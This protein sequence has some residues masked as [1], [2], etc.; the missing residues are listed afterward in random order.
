MKR[1]LF[2]LAVSLFTSVGAF[3]QLQAGSVAPDFTLKDLNGTTY[4]LYT[5]LN[6]GKTVF[7]D[8]SAAWCA[9]C[10]AY[11]NS[12]AL[13]N[14][15]KQHGPAGAPNVNA[16]TTDDV[17]VLFVE[18]ESTNTKAQLT[19]TSTGTT[20]ANYTQG[21]WVTGTPYP[22]LDTNAAATTAF[23]TAYQ[24]GYF[25][26]IYM[27]CR[28]HLI[29]EVGQLT[30]SALYAAAQST[31]P[32]YAP[33]ATVD[34]KAVT[35]SSTGYFICSAN[36]TVK[37]QNYSTTNTI[38]AATIKV[39]SGSTVVSTYNWTGSAAPYEVK[40]VTLPSFT[41]TAFAPYKY[42]VVV[43]GD[44]RASNN[45]SAD[46]LF[47]VY[48][49]ST[50]GTTPWK[51]AFESSS[52][53][54]Y[55]MSISNGYMFPFQTNGSLTVIGVDGAMTRAICIDFPTMAVNGTSELVLGNFNTASATNVSLEFDAAYGQ[56]ISTNTDKL[57]VKVST[58]C[59]ATWST[60]WTKSGTALATTT[61]S[62]SVAFVPASSA[63]WSHQNAL[64]T[65]Y[66]GANM[67]VKIVATSNKG[68]YG[69]LDNIQINNSLNVA[70]VIAP[71]SVSVYPNPA[72]ESA[73]LDF[74]LSKSG[75][76]TVNV[77][78]AV[79]RTVATVANGNMNQGAQHVTIP[80]STLAPGV[81]NISIQTEEG[82][83]TQ[84]LAV[85]K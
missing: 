80:T 20:H 42:E 48:T 84:R 40:S 7:I 81:Y 18:G 62:S 16:T 37:F 66:K 21:N 70:N 31:C 64:L 27:V 53:L 17:M 23:N 26:T 22:I 12:G 25:P 6:Q 38:T 24:I 85:V 72:R 73:S 43:T 2:S 50:A 76:V 61:P 39:Y 82:A 8:V 41:G 74:T 3:A 15:Y 30:T 29:R 5:L 77:I 1:K 75:L 44:T 60:A 13:E 10:W 11:H 9:P 58:D 69:W 32:T 19:G 63:Q 47:K 52:N 68:N 36:P 35:Y 79:G 67:L 45:I 4:N 57:E 59:G 71:N 56:Q 46:S 65:P 49:P 55:R 78:D 54:P 51:E 83:V 34:A 14:L 28:D 33:S